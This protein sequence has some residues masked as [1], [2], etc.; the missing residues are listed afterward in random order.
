MDNHDKLRILL[1]DDQNL[2]REGLASLLRSRPNVEVVAEASNGDQAIQLVRETM[3]DLVL[4]DVHMPVCDGIEAV[5]AIKQEMPLVKVVMLGSSDNDEDLFA[6]IKNGADGYLLKNLDPTQFFAAL[7]GI[8]CGV[9]PISNAAAEKILS[10]FRKMDAQLQHPG[11]YHELLTPKE[12]QTLDLVVKGS[13]NKEIAD[14]LHVS[15]STVKL[16]LR[17][18]MQKLHMQ[19]RIQLAVYAVSQG[20]VHA[21]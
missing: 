9:V 15:E 11:E 13:S 12:I 6:A 18:T 10:E 7:E 21:S 16:H 14:A 2:F 4:M 3:P 5:K 17:N 1:V 8:E 19:N 20:L